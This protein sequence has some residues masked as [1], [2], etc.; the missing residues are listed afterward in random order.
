MRTTL[1]VFP[2]T[3]ALLL[4]SCTTLHQ[5]PDSDAAYAVAA[6]ARGEAQVLDLTET[7]DEDSSYYPSPVPDLTTGQIPGVNRMPLGVNVRLFPA[8]QPFVRSPAKGSQVPVFCTGE[9]TGTHMDAPG[10]FHQMGADMGDWAP[11]DMVRP[12]VLVDVREDGRDNPSLGVDQAYLEAWEAQ[13]GRIPEGAMVLLLTG[14]RHTGE[15]MLPKHPGYTEDAAEFLRS[16]RNVAGVGTDTLSPE[17]SGDLSFPVHKRLLKDEAIIVENLRNLEQLPTRGFHIFM[18]PLLV[19]EAS[20]AQA[21]CLAI[22]GARPHG[23]WSFLELTHKLGKQAP[24][25]PGRDKL[26]S[27]VDIP[28]FE[29]VRLI[30]IQFDLLPPVD[31]IDREAT[32]TIFPNGFHSGQYCVGEMTGTHL[33]F[34][35]RN[36]ELGLDAASYPIEQLIAPVVV[37]NLTKIPDGASVDTRTLMT[38]LQGLQLRGAI[39]ILDTGRDSVGGRQGRLAPG[40]TGE[41]AAAVMAEGALGILSDGHGIDSLA[42]PDRPAQRAVHAAGGVA[43]GFVMEPDRLPRSGAVVALMPIPIRDA[44]GAP[45][46]ILGFVPQ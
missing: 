22:L 35:R 40:L 34:P 46:R 12:A 14:Y 32:A 28:G 7:L 25:L 29:E 15:E 23:H 20:G 1:I 18:A 36:D 41:A 6:V 24:F 8:G 38:S 45:A 10:H 42:N 39:V 19:D 17:V 43:G 30:D 27:D 31:P 4:C 37:A 16:A 9:H 44:G 13:H 11:E 21:R 33:A 26:Y 5:L 3:G 2:I